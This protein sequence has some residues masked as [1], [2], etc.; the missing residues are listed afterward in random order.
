MRAGALWQVLLAA[1]ALASLAEA[2]TAGQ[3]TGAGQTA[4]F[5]QYV[6]QSQRLEGTIGGVWEFSKA[7]TAT[8]PDV[9]ITCDS[10][11]VWPTKSGQN[12]QRTEATGNVVVRGRYLASDKSEWKVIAT[13]SAGSY[14]A[15]A[16]QGELR[17]NVKFD[18]TNLTTGALVSVS[19]EKLVYDVKSR[20]FHF[21]S[22]A[23]PVRVQWEEPTPPPKATG[24][25]APKESG[26]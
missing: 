2:G 19:A 26:K 11:K 23:E 16:G 13:A 4:K 12:V 17:G 1:V 21:E 8:G 25:A 20:Q 22:V 10:L 24:T 15:K 6:I 18:G 3:V 14:D 5:G 9:T 7:V